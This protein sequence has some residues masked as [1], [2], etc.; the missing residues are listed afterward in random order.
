MIAHGLSV[1]NGSRVEIDHSP[2]VIIKLSSAVD[3]KSLQLLHYQAQG[4]YV[5]NNLQLI[6]AFRGW[7]KAALFV[8]NE[9]LTGEVR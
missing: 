1:S 9:A 4:A 7:E 8:Q 6:K 5:A 2:L 3:V